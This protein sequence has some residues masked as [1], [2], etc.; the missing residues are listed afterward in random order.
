MSHSQAIP[1]G[2]FAVSERHPRPN[3]EEAF[4]PLGANGHLV[5]PWQPHPEPTV[6]SEDLL[7]FDKWTTTAITRP[8]LDVECERPD[9]GS[10]ANHYAITDAKWAPMAHALSGAKGGHGNPVRDCAFST[11]LRQIAAAAPTWPQDQAMS[12][13]AADRYRYHRGSIPLNFFNKHQ[14]PPLARTASASEAV[15]TCLIAAGVLQQDLSRPDWAWISRYLATDELKDLITAHRISTS[16]LAPRF[17]R[18]GTICLNAVRD[19]YL[20]EFF[21]IKSIY[22]FAVDHAQHVGLPGHIAEIKT[23]QAALWAAPNVTLYGPKSRNWAFSQ[24][25]SSKEIQ[26][27]EDAVIARRH[28]VT[29]QIKAYEEIEIRANA[30][31]WRHPLEVSRKPF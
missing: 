21:E 14:N 13:A 19:T 9:G 12:H 25:A 24:T 10:T 1:T 16:A 18:F 8:P 2:Y 15:V 27:R 17:F 11:Y 7:S 28:E 31:N 5:Y 23:S 26:V 20:Y 4:G 3:A 22:G 6:K 29:Q 30:R